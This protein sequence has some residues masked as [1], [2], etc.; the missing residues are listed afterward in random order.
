MRNSCKASRDTRLCVVP[1]AVIEGQIVCDSKEPEANIVDYL[2][3]M[4]RAIEAQESLLGDIFGFRRIAEHSGQVQVDRIAQ[5]F[6]ELTNFLFQSDR[7]LHQA[8]HR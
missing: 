2:T 4:E 6:K 1:R 7:S 5:Q 3:A 8:K